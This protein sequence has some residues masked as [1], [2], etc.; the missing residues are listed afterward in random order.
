MRVKSLTEPDREVPLALRLT[1]DPACLEFLMAGEGTGKLATVSVAPKAALPASDLAKIH[2]VADPATEMAFAAAAAAAG[3]PPGVSLPRPFPQMTA[4]VQVLLVPYVVRVRQGGNEVSTV[5][6]EGDGRTKTVV[7]VAMFRVDAGG[8]PGQDP[9]PATL[10]I[11]ATEGDA[12]VPVD[13][14]VVETTATGARVEL[15]CKKPWLARAARTWATFH[16]RGTGPN[17]RRPGVRQVPVQVQPLSARV[18]LVSPADGVL[19]VGGAAATVRLTVVDSHG[20]GVSGVQATWELDPASGSLS[21]A[22]GA[23][24]A[25]GVLETAWTPPT[26]ESAAGLFSGSEVPVTIRARVGG[27][28]VGSAALRLQWK[29]TLVVKVSKP[30]FEP[31]KQSVAL[32]SPGSV[33][34][35]VMHGE[36]AVAYAKVVAGK[37]EGATGSD[38][39]VVVGPFAGTSQAVTVA[40]KL[41][42]GVA[43]VC[44]RLR[45]LEPT[46]ALP[47]APPR[48]QAVVKELATY[49]DAF[50]ARLAADPVD[51]FAATV[52]TAKLVALAVHVQSL[53]RALLLRRW[54]VVQGDFSG[55]CRNLAAA[56]YSRFG[57]KAAGYLAGKM[58]G[59]FQWAATQLSRWKYTR[60]ALGLAFAAVR[61]V[62]DGLDALGR[63]FSEWFQRK[64]FF[65]GGKLPGNLK[66]RLPKKP[67]DGPFPLQK[68]VPD[69]EALERLEKEAAARI[70]EWERKLE[71][72]RQAAESAQGQAASLKAQLAEAERILGESTRDRS[73]A[74]WA[75]KVQELGKQLEAAE[76][77]GKRA[78]Q[79]LQEAGPQKEAAEQAL[80]ALK[81]DRGLLEESCSVMEG[82]LNAILGA[83]NR[84]WNFGTY[85]VVYF[86]AMVFGMFRPIAQKY[87][88][89]YYPALGETF[90]NSLD[91]L[92][93]KA[94]LT[95]MVEKGAQ[96]EVVPRMGRRLESYQ[97]NA[98]AEALSGALGLGR[99]FAIE[100]GEH[101]RPAV[102]WY[103]ETIDANSF[104]AE[105]WEQYAEWFADMLDWIEF[106]LV[107]SVRLTNAILAVLAL[108][109]AI[110]SA[111]GSLAAFL[112]LQPEL[113]AAIESMDKVWDWLK[114]AARGGKA[115]VSAVEVAAILLPAHVAFTA[116]LFGDEGIMRDADAAWGY[117]I[118]E[119]A[120]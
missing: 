45:E 76:D 91:D 37:D 85:V 47:V 48:F 69:H 9:V 25:Q 104:Q 88:N 44:A 20:Q 111:G 52:Y 103:Y 14:R 84:L 68:V 30:G 17:G 67:D 63:K 64:G 100:P 27:E 98:G 51:R 50:V 19:E 99:S 34:V 114:A 31:V 38:G 74:K 120:S 61:K 95:D 107:W 110:P 72:A 41:D 54:G 77:A 92:V 113:T 115:L 56:I 13:W 18:T 119:E 39:R 5:T 7:E 81:K 86:S 79:A 90:W 53:A 6:V 16:L 57:D 96:V 8:H 112:A 22:T 80:E 73:Q 89:K 3:L 116:K 105:A 23:T 24:D 66:D 1:A 11:S 35:T 109:F 78:G 32:T 2:V 12:E 21:A 42:S 40:L 55:F 49:A 65:Q 59:L 43:A 4:D 94:G 118:P 33:A 29:Q 10:E 82:G 28:E 60:K 108:L 62:L 117:P 36:L 46:A 58:K 75:R 87:A 71:A 15:W 101:V 106:G 97:L 83:L 93:F 102:Q 70:A 26:A